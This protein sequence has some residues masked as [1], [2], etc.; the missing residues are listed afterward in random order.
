M[1]FLRRRKSEQQAPAPPVAVHEEVT[2]QSYA[3]KLSFV[4][5]SSDGLRVM[6]YNYAGPDG[7]APPAEMRS[8]NFGSL[9]QPGGTAGVGA[10]AVDSQANLNFTPHFNFKG[11]LLSQ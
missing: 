7:T 3:L 10:I 4:A 6:G 1:S 11:Q 9:F 8:T 5:K 2:A